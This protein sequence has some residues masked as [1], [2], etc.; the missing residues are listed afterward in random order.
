MIGWK[1]RPF[2]FVHIPKCAGTSIEEAF[3]PIVSHFTGFKQM[4]EDDRSQFSLPG[5]K[6]LQHRKLRHYEKHFKLH[7]YFK[8]AF[9]RNP[10][11]RAVSQIEYLKAKTGT[12]LFSGRTFKD[13]IRIYCSSQQTVWAHDLGACQLDYM[14]DAAG[15]LSID[16][17]G[18]FE[19]LLDD[20]RAVCAKIG[21][22]EI[23]ALPHTF[24]SQRTKHYSS[25]YDSES[26]DWIRRRFARDIDNLGYS[27]ETT[28]TVEG[29]NVSVPSTV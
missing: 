14:Q 9:V 4:S 19:T 20:F 25:F 16:F 2:I 6:G 18:R 7:E 15:S 8:F 10:W 22:S 17:I 24:N 23:P 13:N 21:L 27:F 11:D 12:S 1:P 26:A 5:R 3:I 28:P 29:G